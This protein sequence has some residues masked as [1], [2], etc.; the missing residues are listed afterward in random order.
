MSATSIGAR[1]GAGVVRRA[2][3]RGVAIVTALLLTT[4]AVTVVGSLFWQQQVQVRSIENQRMQLQKQWILRGALD[5]AQL[6]L[7]ADATQ[8]NEDHLG[9]PWAVPL[10]ETRLDEYVDNP[11]A[12]PEAS[13][14]VL[15]GTI[16]DA[17][18]LFNLTNLAHEGVVNQRETAA[19]QRLLANLGL[20]GNLATSIANLVAAGQ[21]AGAAAGHGARPGNQGTTTGG[22]MRVEHVDDVLAAEGVTPEALERLREFTVVL[23]DMRSINVNTAP[24]EVLAARIDTLSLAEAAALVAA[25]ET[26]WFR[27]T[28]EFLERARQMGAEG[29]IEHVDVRTEFFLINGHVRMSRAAMDM[30]ALIRRPGRNEPSL[31]WI[32]EY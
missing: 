7:R 25:R 14:A 26:A 1:I 20:D 11:R 24:A 3:Q 30:Q 5:W 16:V 23:P 15:S 9:E 31:L 17:Q 29:A 27:S 12:D 10:A 13:D 19:L 2:R 8:S 22:Q 32:R 6:I 21:R 28:N 18:S 4:L